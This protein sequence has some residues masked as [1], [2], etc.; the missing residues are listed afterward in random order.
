MNDPLLSSSWYR[1]ENLRPRRSRHTTFHRH[2]YREERWYVLQNRA[3]G[4]C[5]L[6]PPSAHLIVGLMDGK[7]TTQEIWEEAAQ[8]LGDECPTQ[9]E[10]IRLLGMMHFAE[11]L[12]CDL[13]PD[14]E[15][16]FR[17]TQRRDASERARKLLHPLSL[18]IPLVDPDAFLARWA[19]WLR[20]IF[21][22]YGA[23]VWALVVVAALL[24]GASHWTELTQDFTS[25]LLSSQNMLV[26]AVAFPI[27]KLLH[28]L[29]HGFAAKV[30]GAE[31]HEMGVMFLVL[32]PV[33]YIDA[34]AAN[35]FPDKHRRM[36][37]AG[38][39]VLVETFLASVAL[40]VWLAVEPGFVRTL[41]YDV[42]WI[43]GASALLF[44]A[45]PLLRFD[46]YFVLADWLEI[47]N[48]GSR[49]NEYLSYLL[50][51]H[52]FG[53]SGVRNP[54]H[55][56]GEATWF[57]VYGIAA[58]VYRI[59]LTLGIALFVAGRFFVIG[60]LLAGLSIATQIVMP[61]FQQTLNILSAPRF[62]QRRVRVLA[63][64]VGAIVSVASALLF[65]PVP[66][67]TT[68][69][70][71]VWLPE[72]SQIRAGTDAF[73]TDLL[74]D[75]RS[76]V[77]NG[78]ALIAAHDPM[79]QAHVARLEAELRSL[80]AR[81]YKE[82]VTDFA[83]ARI[84]EEEVATARASLARATE[85]ERDII[86]RSSDIGELVIPRADDLIGRMVRQGELV[87]YVIGSDPP[88]AKVVLDE[89]HAALVRDRTYL[90]EVRLA[91]R[92]SDIRPARIDRVFPS[93]T[94]RL[95]TRALGSAG[96]GEIAVD[97]TDIEGLR[98][99]V[100][101][102][103]IDL[104]L[105]DTWTTESIGEAIYVR[106]DHGMEP[107]ALRAYRGIRRLLLSRLSV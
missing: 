24:A 6:L 103:E 65:L 27:V 34:S 74:V 62:G 39:G 14:I 50:E 88:S 8:Q 57:V 44:N 7:R 93:A 107:L 105:P 26:V 18:R 100:P 19:G 11:S 33:P 25:R 42:I 20:P 99:L 1:V 90:V 53:M 92:L 46:G 43:S 31:I 95:P 61:I 21:S 41:A 58:F 49:S 94:D 80:E 22:G 98:T 13:S 45:N 32:M 71:V 69:R 70:G 30:W 36:V 37:V 55:A 3:T 10:T 29:G 38:A 16:M 106:F 67:Y 87:G 63:L 76:R 5:Q 82:R 4:R 77:Q 68:A 47:P 81:H 51:K 89:F 54:A 83:Q 86:I 64:S 52:L 35:V 72:R 48:L 23:V 15:E 66:L 12:S 91:R 84:T 28:E 101:V 59:L 40:F 60:A 79:L 78:E 97:T 85:R 104:A 75:S 73:V 56:S 17:R 2:I 102:V 9:D 96:G